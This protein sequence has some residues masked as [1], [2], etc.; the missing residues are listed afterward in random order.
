MSI[1]NINKLLQY[2]QCVSIE[3]IKFEDKGIIG[4]KITSICL[5]SK[6][7]YTDSCNMCGGCDPAESNIYTSFEYQQIQNCN[8]EIFKESGLDTKYLQ[9][10]RD[11]LYP[12]N[13]TINDKVV[14]V[15]CYDNVENLLYLP[16][17][18]KVIHR[19]SWCF[20]DY[21]R[22]FKCRIHPV[23]SITCIMPHLR[24]FHV[25]GSNKSSIG[26]CQFGRNWALKCPVMLVP[27]EDEEQ[28]KLNKQN[29]IDKLVR[30]NQVGLDLNIKTHIPR[31]IE[32]IMDIQYDN[33]H[34]YLNKD[35]LKPC[36]KAKKL[37]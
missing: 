2:L 27:P 11:G 20:Q 31:I 9:I 12:K 19:C 7:F 1:D 29:R 32:F 36:Y 17:R 4:D 16:T 13:Y 30:L 33:Y 34:N 5:N 22:T 3:P 6:F 23:E 18:E 26:I 28:F 37:F 8:I 14:T 35:I 24:I 10:L 25:K 15:W 21:D